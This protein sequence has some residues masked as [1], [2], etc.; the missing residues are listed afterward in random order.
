MLLLY[1]PHNY[2]CTT[3]CALFVSRSTINLFSGVFVA[4]FPQLQTAVCFKYD[5]NDLPHKRSCIVI[6]VLHRFVSFLNSL[7]KRTQA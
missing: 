3:V 7:A 5:T 1:A 2:E 6:P 4:W